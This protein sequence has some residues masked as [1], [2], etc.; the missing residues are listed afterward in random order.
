MTSILTILVY[1]IFGYFAF[2][3]LFCLPFLGWG[4]AKVDPDAANSGWGLKLLWL[5]GTV[6][7]WPI[8]LR[9]WMRK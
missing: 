8:L 1:A 7:F 2:G 4:L 3:G 5:P 9:K 6:A